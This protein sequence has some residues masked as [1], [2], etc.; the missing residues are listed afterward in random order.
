M[1]KKKENKSTD[2]IER[3][4]WHVVL[5]YFLLVGAYN[6]LFE[7]FSPLTATIQSIIMFQI[8][9]TMWCVCVCMYEAS[10]FKINK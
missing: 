2:V 1:G 7:E 10:L 9:N 3:G 6:I 8:T 4:I 5:F